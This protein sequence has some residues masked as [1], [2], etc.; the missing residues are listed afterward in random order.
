MNQENAVFAAPAVEETESDRSARLRAKAAT[1]AAAEFDEAAVYAQMLAEERAKRLARITNG[2]EVDLAND[3]RGFPAD[4]DK[5]KIFRG[6]NKQD[7]PYVPLSLNGL[8]LKVPR[9]QEVI[10]PHAFVAD[11]LDLCVEDITVKSQGGYVT[12]PAHRFPYSFIG[13]ATPEEYKKFQEEQKA[14]AQREMAQAA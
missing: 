5:I 4:Y 6:S 11:C 2:P 10:I 12:H 9:D 14:K 8:V 1:Q 7:L 3:T 13:K